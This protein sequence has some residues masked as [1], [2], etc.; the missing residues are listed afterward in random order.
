MDELKIERVGGLGGFGLDNS[1]IKSRGTVSF[2]GLSEADKRA[3]LELFSRETP[4]AASALRDGFTYRIER[5][6]KTIEV[7]EEFVPQFLRS[8]VKDTLE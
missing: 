3:V 2:G 6:E 8:S 5:G 1:R 7:P 4:K